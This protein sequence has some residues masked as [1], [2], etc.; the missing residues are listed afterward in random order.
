MTSRSPAAA[1]LLPLAVF[2]VYGLARLVG[3]SAPV[4]QTT[5]PRPSLRLRA[6]RPVAD[7]WQLWRLVAAIDRVGGAPTG[8]PAA[9]WL[10]ALVGGVG[11]AVAQNERVA[12]RRAATSK[13]DP[14]EA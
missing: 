4:A 1:L 7:G 3:A 5:N 10:I 6:L 13:V 11:A 2:G 12:A 9:F 8:H 14:R